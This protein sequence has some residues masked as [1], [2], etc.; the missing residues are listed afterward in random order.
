MALAA[1]YHDPVTEIGSD[2]FQSFT[3]LPAATANL[4]LENDMYLKAR[5]VSAASDVDGTVASTASTSFTDLTGASVSITTSG[6]S[7]LLIIA[8]WWWGGSTALNASMTVLVDGVNQGNATYGLSY[9]YVA[10]A[11]PLAASLVW[12]ATGLTAGAHTVKL[13]YKTSTGTLTVA[14][15]SFA[16]VEI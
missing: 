13:Q 9:G 4:L 15:F 12:V 11:N 1:T 16:V 2:G 3:K 7:K 5:P 14:G 10:N 6:T 8:N